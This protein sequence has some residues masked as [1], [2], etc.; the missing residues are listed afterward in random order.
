MDTPREG[1]DLDLTEDELE[2]LEREL[3]GLRGGMAR[4]VYVKGVEDVP[5][6]DY[7]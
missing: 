7:L 6:G 5:T 3:S 1:T 4:Y 2:E